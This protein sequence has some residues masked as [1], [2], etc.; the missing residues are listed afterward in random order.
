MNW[1]V[2]FGGKAAAVLCVHQYCDVHIQETIKF[3]TMA[4]DFSIRQI[5]NRMG[6]CI[7]VRN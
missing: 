2:L 3:N 5:R 4:S 7:I 1:I 6:D